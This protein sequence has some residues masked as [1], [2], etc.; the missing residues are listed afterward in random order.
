MDLLSEV[1]VYLITALISVP[2]SK[3]LGCR[4]VLGY[5]MAGIIIGASLLRLIKDPDHIF[6]FAE[7][8]V[9]F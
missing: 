7:L 9:I 1:V 5:L 8:G 6:H 3:R 4:S 2:I